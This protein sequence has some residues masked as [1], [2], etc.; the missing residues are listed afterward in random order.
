MIPADDSATFADILARS[1]EHRGD[2]VGCVQAVVVGAG[3]ERADVG[4]PG[5]IGERFRFHAQLLDQDVALDDR[6]R[7][8][9]FAAG[10]HDVDLRRLLVGGEVGLQV[11]A[12]DAGVTVD[13]PTARG[14]GRAPHHVL[15]RRVPGGEVEAQVGE[16]VGQERVDIQQFGHFRGCLSFLSEFIQV[17]VHPLDEVTR[18]ARVLE[19]EHRRALHRIVDHGALDAAAQVH[20]LDAAVVR[21]DQGA[22]GGGQRD[23]KVALG[24]LAV[25]ADRSG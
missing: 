10:A 15:A 8:D 22:L 18:T 17:F 2:G 9:P 19:G 11:E 20:Y 21:R 5:V 1:D 7:R 24:V 13:D 3:E 12:L 4:H 23:Q 14:E 25:D 16:L 6:L